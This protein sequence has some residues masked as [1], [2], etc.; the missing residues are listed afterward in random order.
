MERGEESKIVMNF[1]KL[2]YIRGKGGGGGGANF[3]NTAAIDRFLLPPIRVTYDCYEL[4]SVAGNTTT[5]RHIF[6]QRLKF[7]KKITNKQFDLICV[8]S[9]IPKRSFHFFF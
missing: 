4:K 5:V 8:L 3:L 7:L 6:L 2:S 9:C 1:V